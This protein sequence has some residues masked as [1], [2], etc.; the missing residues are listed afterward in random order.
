MPSS[1]TIVSDSKEKERQSMCRMSVKDCTYLTHC[2]SMLRPWWMGHLKS[3]EMFSF[4]QTSIFEFL[5]CSQQPFQNVS[6]ATMKISK[7]FI[8]VL[9]LTFQRKCVFE[10]YEIRKISW[11]KN[12]NVNRSETFFNELLFGASN[13]NTIQLQSKTRL[14]RLFKEK[15]SR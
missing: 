2:H 9:I 1:T 13:L 7:V 3:P 8:S 11:S 15:L 14:L 12:K 10:T 5:D 6:A 4:Q